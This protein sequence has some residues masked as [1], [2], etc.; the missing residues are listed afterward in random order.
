MESKNNYFWLK[1]L[2]YSMG[3]VLTVGTITMIFFVYHKLFVMPPQK[4]QSATVQT[5][6]P[7]ACKDQTVD[8][9]KR[10]KIINTTVGRDGLARTVILKEQGD[11][12]VVTV[13]GCTGEIT[14]T[15]TLPAHP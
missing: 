7:I 11:Y 4:V 15:L 2:V 1:L 12:E 5:S 14:H 6:Q 13:D 3:V 9:I 8:L 10:G